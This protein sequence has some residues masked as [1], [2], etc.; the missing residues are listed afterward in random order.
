MPRR[1][2]SKRRARAS[3]CR[4]R[5]QWNEWRRA[6][7]RFGHVDAMAD[8]GSRETGL[9]DASTEGPKGRARKLK[10]MKGG[11]MTEIFRSMRKLQDVRGVSAVAPEAP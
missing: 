7:E 8:V 9:A 6:S 11:K 4:D 10:W 2:Q 5:Q 3:R 1:R